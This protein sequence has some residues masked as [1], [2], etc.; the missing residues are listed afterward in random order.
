M[1]VSITDGLAEELQAQLK[2]RGTLDQEVERRLTETLH[3]PHG[4]VVLSLEELEQIAQQLG[5]GLPIR[6][7]ADL[8]RALESVAQLH[9][10]HVRLV[11]TP[12]QLSLIAEKANKH[13]LTV[14][15][16][17]GHVAAKLLVDVF[18]VAPAADGVFYTPGFTADAVDEDLDCTSETP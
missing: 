5:T 3:A 7:K 1:R 18:N 16:F 14:A 17:V 12:A 10:G 15:Q 9:F 6:T 11:W 4:R 2:G 8:L 13:G